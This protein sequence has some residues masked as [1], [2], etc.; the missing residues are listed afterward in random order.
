MIQLGYAGLCCAREGFWLRR[1]VCRGKH[2]E[3]NLIMF[4]LISGRV[5]S[6]LSGQCQPRHI[7][8]GQLLLMC[9]AERARPTRLYSADW[10]C[11]QTSARTQFANRWLESRQCNKFR[12]QV[13]F[14][15]R[16]RENA[17]VVRRLN[18]TVSC[19]LSRLSGRIHMIPKS[20]ECFCRC[21]SH[22]Q[23]RVRPTKHIV[24]PKRKK[25]KLLY[26]WRWIIRLRAPLCFQ[27]SP[28]K[29]GNSQFVLRRASQSETLS[30]RRQNWFNCRRGGSTDHKTNVGTVGNALHSENMSFI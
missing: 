13:C 14:A 11:N 12:E 1:D 7:Q 23:L 6:Q 28:P 21:V 19:D 24:P 16:R 8:W 18:K 20:F 25:W 22:N 29:C 2:R 3:L 17:P 27:G 30:A 26:C 10:L 4:E 9:L 5:P 15:L